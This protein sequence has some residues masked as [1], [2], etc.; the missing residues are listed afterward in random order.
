MASSLSALGIIHTT[1]SMVP[2]II[3]AYAFFR[4]GRINP[5]KKVGRWYQYGMLVSVVTSFGLTSTAGLNSGHALGLIALA[6]IFL[7]RNAIRLRPLGMFRKYL[8]VSSMTLSY[9]ILMIPGINETLS[10]LPVGNPIGNGPDSPEVKAAILA[11][12]LIFLFGLSYQLLRLHTRLSKS[13]DSF[14]TQI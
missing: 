6:A 13:R 11:A 1:L 4:Y 5:H 2:L 14:S 10:R 7:G 9:L 3:G 8:Q 12:F